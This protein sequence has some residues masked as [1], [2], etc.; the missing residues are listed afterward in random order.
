[1]S[2]AEIT[3]EQNKI[4]CK[5]KNDNC[6][7]IFTYGRTDDGTLYWQTEKIIEIKEEE[8]E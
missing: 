8:D 3:Q 2:K 4:Q 7:D 6:T 1:M 5:I